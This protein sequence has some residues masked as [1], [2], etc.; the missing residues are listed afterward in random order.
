MLWDKVLNTED[1]HQL[2]RQHWIGD[3]EDLENED[4]ISI[5]VGMHAQNM[6]D[7]SLLK[8]CEAFAMSSRTRYFKRKLAKVDNDIKKKWNEIRKINNGQRIKELQILPLN[9]AENN[10]NR[11]YDELSF[12]VKQLLRTMYYPPTKTFEPLTVFGIYTK[13][14]GV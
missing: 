8:L 5:T 9:I 6:N 1:R 10:V 2:I 13:D 3:I 14:S 12:T 4:M 11:S 7:S